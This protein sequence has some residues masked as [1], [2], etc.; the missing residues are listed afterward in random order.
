MDTCPTG[1]RPLVGRTCDYCGDNCT[2]ALTFG[3]NVTVVNG[4]TNLFMNFNSDI[5]INGNLENTFKVVT[6]SRRLLE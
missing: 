1:Y 5:N 3:T 4:Q 6:P 2:E